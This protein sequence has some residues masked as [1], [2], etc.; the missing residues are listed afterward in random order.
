MAV[1]MLAANASG[2]TKSDGGDFGDLVLLCI[3]TCGFDVHKCQA[4]HG[5]LC[6]SLAIV[7]PLKHHV[8]KRPVTLQDAFATIAFI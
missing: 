1:P 6:C 4:S 8:K 7:C 3:A 2:A 5:F